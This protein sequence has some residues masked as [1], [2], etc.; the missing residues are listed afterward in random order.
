MARRAVISAV[1][2]YRSVRYANPN[3]CSSCYTAF[4]VAQLSG[5]LKLE[6]SPYQSLRLALRQVDNTIS[7]RSEYQKFVDVMFYADDDKAIS[8]GQ[9]MERSRSLVALF[10]MDG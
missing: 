6:Q 5:A 9:A 4:A 2:Q 7:C 1:G 8:F 3:V 10:A